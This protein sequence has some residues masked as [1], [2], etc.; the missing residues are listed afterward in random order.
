MFTRRTATVTMSAPEASCACA[1]TACDG[2][3]PVPTISRDVNVRPAIDE[4][5]PDHRRLPAADE[6]DD[7]D[8][9]AVGRR[10]RWRS[11]RAATTVRLRS[12]ATRR[13]SMPSD[14]RA[15][16]SMVSGAGSS[17]GWP[18]SESHV[19]TR[20]QQPRAYLSRRAKVKVKS[21]KSMSFAPSTPCRIA[22]RLGPGHG[23]RGP[24]C[25]MPVMIARTSVS[26]ENLAGRTPR[27][28]ERPAVLPV[29]RARP[30]SPS[31]CSPAPA[32]VR[33][34]S[35]MRRLPKGRGDRRLGL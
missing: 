7:L 3:L 35:R 29:T 15:G 6:V 31:S 22:R 11:A 25:R 30:A 2:Y 24:A 16:V 34:L 9:V 5:G 20:S 21:L 18:L 32:P 4:G 10:P 12:T 28:A 23:T 1:I 33:R 8:L 19:D 27:G 17:C 13:P 14:C 26:T